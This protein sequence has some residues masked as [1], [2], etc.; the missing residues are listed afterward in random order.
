MSIAQ[1]L[2]TITRIEGG[3]GLLD[4]GVDALELGAVLGAL[5]MRALGASELAGFCHASASR[6]ARLD[7]VPAGRNRGIA[8]VS[9]PSYSGTVEHPNLMPALALLLVRFGVPVRSEERRVGKEC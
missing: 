9:I 3:E 4:G 5:A 8:P 1:V 7:F 2:R 6:T